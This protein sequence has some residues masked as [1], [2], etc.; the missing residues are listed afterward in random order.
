MNWLQSQ[1]QQNPQKLFIQE[2]NHK[3]SYM[4]V[5]EMVQAYSQA[6]LK[7]GIQPQD[8]ILI[9]L[10]GSIEMAE[11]ILAC[12][13]VG[14]VTAPIS[15]RLSNKERKAIIDTIQPRLI[16]TNW[17]ERG[18]FEDVSFP[19]TC[20][21]ELL[22]SSGGCSIYIN[23]YKKNLDDVCTII[24]TSG[25]T[26]IPKAVQLTYGN[27]ETSCKNWNG[28]LEFESTD[29]FLCCLPL[30]HIGGLA[31]L[32]RALIY[33]FSINLV[34]TFEAGIISNVISKHPVTIISLVP[35]MLKRILA[36]KGGL[37]VLKTLRHILLGGGPSSEN[38]LDICFQEKLPIV[39]VY[40]MSETCS[41]TF[42]LKLLD[43][44]Q[45]KFYSG[46]PFPGTKVWIENDEIHISGP[47]VMKG[48][49][50][51]RDTK[52]IHN[53][54]DLGRLDDDNLLFL[55]IRRKDLI[56]SGG[57][58]INPLEVE[59]CLMNVSGISDAAVV[60]EEDDEWGQR[61]TAYIVHKSAPLENE[62]LHNELTKTLSP[63][64]IPKDYIVVSHI[65][66]NELGKIVYEKLNTL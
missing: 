43:E 21:E 52:G 24:L 56:V 59:E 14:A 61:V 28:F 41:G 62:L 8:R 32:I 66:R 64:K 46:R 16:I 12:F 60:G 38:L 20:I 49:V 35:T 40:G 57:E 1:V 55:H 6:F 37:D 48:Y 25:T 45:H 15:R 22:S 51:E 58:N 9:Y 10:P 26:G 18:V 63:Y 17:D 2:N 29:Q 4:D 23:E 42:G 3:Y 50:G 11:I 54:H 44:P 30:H 7:E 39:K 5:A 13:E 33:G 65:P 36:I 31:V 53:S 27:F 47:M 19:L 34:H